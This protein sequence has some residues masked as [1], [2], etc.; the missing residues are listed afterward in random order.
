MFT[1]YILKLEQNKYYVGLTKYP[2]SRIQEH[3]NGTGS[4]FTKLYK[5][6]LIIKQIQTYDRYDEDKIVKQCMSKYG[7][8]NVRGGS[9]SNIELSEP[10]IDFLEK[11]IMHSRNA[12]F[13][14]LKRGHFMKNCNAKTNIRG[15]FLSNK[16]LIKNNELKENELN[17]DLSNL[18][19]LKELNIDD[20]SKKY[21]LKENELNNDLFKNNELKENELNNDLFKNNELKENDFLKKDLEDLFDL[22]IEFLNDSKPHIVNSI[23]LFQK[24]YKLLYSNYNQ[25]YIRS[26]DIWNT[27]F[28]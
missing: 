17:N 4:A 21:E 15:S 12:C 28:K 7:I 19:K 20:L 11:E 5:P 14:C 8:L 1:I 9:Y 24:N 27:Y 2:E 25:L 16:F 6:L 23:L 13:R 26:C 22:F 3:F 10:I 18:I